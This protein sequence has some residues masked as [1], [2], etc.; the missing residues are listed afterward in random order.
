MELKDGLLVGKAL[1]EGKANDA[2]MQVIN[3]LLKFAYEKFGRQAFRNPVSKFLLKERNTYREFITPESG[4]W[5]ME[6]ALPSGTN[7]PKLAPPFY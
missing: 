5:L 6:K 3:K 7:M 1:V 2:K 4:A